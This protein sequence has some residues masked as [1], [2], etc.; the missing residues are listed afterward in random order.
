[1]SNDGRIVGRRVGGRARHI[2]EPGRERVSDRAHCNIVRIG[3]LDRDG[4]AVL[5][6]GWRGRA[7]SSLG[8]HEPFQPQRRKCRHVRVRGRAASGDGEIPTDPG[9]VVQVVCAG[10]GIRERRLGTDRTPDCIVLVLEI[11]VAACQWDPLFDLTGWHVVCIHRAS[12]RVAVAAEAFC[13]T[14]AGIG[15]AQERVTRP[16]EDTACRAG[17]VIA[18]HDLRR[19]MLLAVDIGVGLLDVQPSCG[20]VHDRNH[21]KRISRHSGAGHRC[22][23]DRGK[24]SVGAKEESRRG[25]VVV[26][27]IGSVEDSVHGDERPGIGWK[28]VWPVELIIRC[29]SDVLDLAAQLVAHPNVSKRTCRGDI[30]NWSHQGRFKCPMLLLC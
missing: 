24:R 22:L 9:P 26:S 28:Y 8:S 23:T 30:R 21:F 20:H 5:C 27:E 29:V 18:D 16:I 11:I 13:E 12:H 25:I 6:S 2:G 7:V 4:V 1:L 19:V 10:A 14:V 15:P 17:T 3:V